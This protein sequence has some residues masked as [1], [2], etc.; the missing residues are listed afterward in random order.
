M[1]W[2]EEL[3]L[4]VT[5]K[6]VYDWVELEETCQYDGG[7]TAKDKYM[8]S[9]WKLIHSLPS[10]QKRKF[11]AFC[12]GSD[13][14]PVR[15]LSE[16]KLTIVRNGAEDWKLPTSHTCFSILLL[17]EYSTPE[18]LEKKTR[19]SY[20]ELHWFRIALINLKL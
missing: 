7:F 3:E 9:F 6:K 10:D 2:P 16:V 14:V 11:L 4:L 1:F 19:N 5:G 18:I 13:R 20:S 17:P 12:T 15:G 8:K